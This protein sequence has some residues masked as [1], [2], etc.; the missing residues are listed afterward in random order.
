[1][2]KNLDG[3]M[4][5]NYKDFVKVLVS[6]EKGIQDSAALDRI[7]QEFM[8]SDTVSLL[9]EDF[10]YTIDSL[11]E[12][13]LINENAII[14]EEKDDMVN[15]VGNLVNDAELLQRENKEGNIFQVVNFSVVC[16]DEEGNKTYINCSA[17]GEKAELPKD[18][19]KGDFV[20]MF[21]QLRTSTGDDGK[22][23]TNLRVLSSK[24]L[25]A[26]EQ[27]KDQ[28]E[29]KDSVLGAIKKFQAEDKTKEIEKKGNSLGEGR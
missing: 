16:K 27:M 3:M 25:K 29:K 14:E 28:S 11:K 4:N 21:G 6:L 26:K 17:Y 18:F 22:E 10:D 5:D 2:K 8:D 20:K 19:K 24:L 13:G 9:H 15:L 12:Q 23:Y 7:Y 1:M